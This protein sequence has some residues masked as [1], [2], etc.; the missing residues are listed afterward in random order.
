MSWDWTQLLL[1]DAGLLVAATATL[2]A[3]FFR[4]LYRGR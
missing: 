1:L 3:L 2:L 4:D